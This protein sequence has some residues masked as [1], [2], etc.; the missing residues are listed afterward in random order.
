[1]SAHAKLH[2]AVILFILASIVMA[3]GDKLHFVG[4]PGWAVQLWPLVQGGALLVYVT[5][6]MFLGPQITDAVA[7]QIA[8]ATGGTLSVS[9]T[10]D[11]AANLSASFPSTAIAT[12]VQTP[13]T[14]Q[15]KP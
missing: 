15:A 6:R 11:A 14:S 4:L 10:G 2:V 13:N 12:A 5:G 9:A 7:K 3:V 8:Q 1:M